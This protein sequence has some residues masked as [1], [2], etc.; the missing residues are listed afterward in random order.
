MYV[1]I[2]NDGNGNSAVIQFSTT[3][4]TGTGQFTWHTCGTESTIGTASTTG[5]TLFAGAFDNVYF[6]S[7]SGSSPSG[8]LYVCGNTSA[9]ATVYQ[10]RITSNA[11]SAS[12]TS[13][14]A[15]STGNTTCFPVTEVFSASTDLIFLSVQSLGSTATKVN[16][17]SNAGCLMSFSVPTT[18]GGTLPTGTAAAL[19]AV[20]GA[21]GVVIDNTV[22][23][24]TMHTSQVY[25]STLTS[26]MAVQ[27]SQAALK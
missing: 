22:A 25:F 1:V 7:T 26:G 2:G 3:V 18:L 13:V 20:G 19:A 9:D 11:I 27:A 23:P 16:C 14:L 24:G 21:S 4:G 6:T 17:P 12:G 8:N 10:V 5:V 15:V